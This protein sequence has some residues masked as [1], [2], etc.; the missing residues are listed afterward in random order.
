MTFYMA[1]PAPKVTTLQAPEAV[2][3]EIIDLLR[4][5]SMHGTLAAASARVPDR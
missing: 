5:H 2:V 1:L 4:R 3:A